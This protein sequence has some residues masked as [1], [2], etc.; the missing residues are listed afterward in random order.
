MVT[1]TMDVSSAFRKL[2]RFLDECEE[3]RVSSVELIKDTP[4]SDGALTAEIE[5]SISACPSKEAEGRAAISPC[6][7]SVDGD[8]R[9]RFEVESSQAIVPTNRDVSVEPTDA[10]F[11]SDGTITLTLSASVPTGDVVTSKKATRTHR[12][13]TL[14]T[15]ATNAAN[16]LTPIRTEISH[17][18]EIPSSS[19][20]CTNRVIRSPRCL[21]NSGWT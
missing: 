10:S 9:L 21:T 18:S 15:R 3:E 2:A 5:V 7:M 19:L 1:T 14:T 13:P 8:G 11:G 17:R 6:A 16:P 12:R 20:R 4:E